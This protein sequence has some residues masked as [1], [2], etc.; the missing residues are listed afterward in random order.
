MRRLPRFYD[1]EVTR[2]YILVGIPAASADR[3]SGLT[4]AL[5]QAGPGRIKTIEY[6]PGARG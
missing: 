5:E 3:L 2:G 6:R 4:S 1:P